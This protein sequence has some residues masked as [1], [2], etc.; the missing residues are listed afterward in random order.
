MKKVI[1]LVLSGVL[2]VV[3]LAQSLSESFKT[4]T[5]PASVTLGG[6]AALTGGSSD[7]DGDGWLR[8]VSPGQ[9]PG[10]MYTNNALNFGGGGTISFDYTI[11]GGSGA[12]GMAVIFYDGSQ[13][14]QVGGG[15]GYLGYIDSPTN[16]Y[17]G[18][19]ISVY[20]TTFA[21]GSS[22][23][24][25]IRGS[26]SNGL[27][28]RG[29]YNNG[30]VLHYS[31]DGSRPGQDTEK[32]RKLIVNLSNDRKLTISVQFGAGN[33]PVAFYTDFD[34][35]ADF[36][37]DM[38]NIKVAIVGSVGGLGDIFEIRNLQIGKSGNVTA[39]AA[40]ERTTLSAKLNG[41][42]FTTTDTTDVRFLFGS[43]PGV[44]SDSVLVLDNQL[45]DSVLTPISHTLTG[46]SADT[47]YYYAVSAVNDSGY[48]VSGEVNFKTLAEE[49]ALSSN[50]LLA[51]SVG[52]STVIL[53]WSKTD[54]MVKH[55]VVVKEGSPVA[56]TPDDGV[57][58]LYNS[59]FGN[60]A[61]NADGSYIV[62]NGSLDSIEVTN[63]VSTTDY[64]VTIFDYYG[65]NSSE[66]YNAESVLTGSFS[67][68]ETPFSDATPEGSDGISWGDLA[69]ADYDQ[70]GRMDYAV[71]NYNFLDV[72]RNNGEGFSQ[73]RINGYYSNPK[74]AWGDVNNDGY[75][76]L[77]FSGDGYIAV[78]AMGDGESWYAVTELYPELG[79][80]D[81]VFVDY[82]LDGDQDIFVTGEV[83]GGPRKP[84][85]SGTLS[86]AVF[87]RNDS[88]VFS[89]LTSNLPLLSDPSINFGD[90]NQDGYPDLL[91]TGS[92]NDWFGGRFTQV[93]YGNG[94]TQFENAGLEIPQA[95]RG[96]AAIADFNQDGF[97]DFIYTGATGEGGRV[98]GYYQG[99]EMG[100]FTEVT[101]SLTPVAR[102]SVSAGDIDNDGD[103]DLVF[104]GAPGSSGS[105]IS[106]V[107][108]NDG[109]GN[110][111]ETDM[112]L[113]QL[114]SSTVAL[115]DFNDDLN[116]DLLI[117]GDS[118]ESS[119][120]Y[121]LRSNS[122]E[123]NTAP[124]APESGFTS[125]VTGNTVELTWNAGS[126]AETSAGGLTYNVR[127]GTASG[128]SGIVRP[129]SDK[130]LVGEEVYVDYSTMP[131]AGNAGPNTFF[132]TRRLSPGTYYWSVQTVDPTYQV[133][134]F[135]TGQSFEITAPLAPLGPT[136][137]DFVIEAD[138]LV[139]N[140]NPLEVSGLTHYNVYQSDGADTL[141][142]GT[143][144]T[145]FY[146]ITSGLSRGT[147]YTFFVAGVVEGPLEGEWSSLVAGLTNFD[148][149]SFPVS[150]GYRNGM[151]VGD[152][153]NDGKPDLINSDNYS[154]SFL[155]NVGVAGV[156]D[157]GYQPGDVMFNEPAGFAETPDYT[158][159]LKAADY[160]ND[161]LL[162]LAVA[163]GI[164]VYILR[165]D[166]IDPEMGYPIFTEV[167]IKPDQPYHNSLVWADLDNDGDLDLVSSRN[168]TGYVMVHVNQLNNE[169]EMPFETV[170]IIPDGTTE[171]YLDAADIDHDGDQDLLISGFAST[172]S[173]WESRTVAIYLNTGL[174]SLWTQLEQSF[175]GSFKGSSRF[176]D[177]NNDGYADFIS[178][179][180]IGDGGREVHLYENNQE[181]GF[182]EVPTS[183][184]GFAASTATWGD[185]NGDG[186]LDLVLTGIA[187]SADNGDE[188]ST[189]VWFNNG[190]G[191]F[192]LLPEYFEGMLFGSVELSDL[193]LDG[194]LD[195]VTLGE[196]MY[197]GGGEALARTYYS[198]QSLQILVNETGTGPNLPD[199]PASAS[200]S[201]IGPDYANLAW[202]AGNDSN[203]PA[204][205]LTYNIRVYNQI[206]EKELVSVMSDI[207]TGERL[208]AA[209]GNT[210][211]ARTFSIKGLTDGDYSWWIQTI[212][213]ELKASA[214][215]QGP[216]FTVNHTV[217]V[218]LVAFTAVQKADQVVL[219]WTTKTE[220][221][222]NGFEIEKK[223]D[224]TKAESQWISVG[225]V[226]GA[227]TTTEE[228][229]YRFITSSGKD[230]VLFRLKQ[231]DAD[232]K[233]SYS[234]VLAYEPAAPTVLALD[235]NYPNP[236]NPSTS[237]PVSLPV[238]GWVSMKVYDVTGREV[239]ILMNE[240]KEA[241]F[242]TV[243]FNGAG[244]SSGLYFVRLE[245][246]GQSLVK[247][248]TLLK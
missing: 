118:G 182:I 129:S 167:Y 185:L 224:G 143:S 195:V 191:D 68:L 50:S 70:D 92:S 241:G 179:G 233:V 78:F 25:A 34:M 225:F 61:V 42:I 35:S 37:S 193:D 8:L 138:T 30:Q 116:L 245:T 183:F 40:T 236:F 150:N 130:K 187:G 12:D 123:E 243:P 48:V 246:N 196:R 62:Y 115:G 240:K 194:D 57:S 3:V 39:L 154:L 112:M 19:A 202:T 164:Y 89:E 176:G 69:W 109:A 82:D 133:S 135:S 177:F 54:E 142:I 110:F 2:P 21:N 204:S 163:S 230:R 51:D 209:P 216:D 136:G 79:A 31:L 71:T 207:E 198:G 159:F 145:T 32:Y 90:L 137:L 231:L 91:L 114:S 119:S 146:R 239:A 77:L 206:A 28:Y 131:G 228:K 184:T 100:G 172:S 125:T 152:F 1:M 9:Q 103:V 134:E 215:I 234:D 170:A 122:N 93:Y 247:K 58:Y 244:L 105:A 121:L 156:E 81:A 75:L 15:G 242:Y 190:E 214:W 232:G 63:L 160:N 237:I 189:Q 76:E 108:V 94:T 24:I 67:T 4:S 174:D 140:W 221:N 211:S 38:T 248:L 212:N 213:H 10:Y 147:F 223:A 141:L 127:I 227:G 13:T 36:P 97:A 124:S 60:T 26:Q 151:V 186:N 197:S 153:D 72:Y 20:S 171:G 126:D 33:E 128:E 98:I 46:L 5:V 132:I 178:I 180:A 47:Y 102:A 229:T 165:N 218:E 235:Q 168:D 16:I 59:S 144:D 18:V 203:T 96:E 22:N 7:P 148:L 238:A 44:Y 161:G 155:K 205:A 85:A 83:G 166:G 181:G 107:A 199:A 14:F 23:S 29:A 226:A 200:V 74:L 45:P 43:T 99:S 201:F 120:L 208:L 53:D 87:Y 219:S 66:N 73:F 64:Y 80:M 222:N 173:D 41:T 217:P 175:P 158:A 188:R 86:N 88:G 220:T 101:H 65:S 52:F 95:Y 49:P 113:P 106:Y 192:T 11:W 27:P 162:D 104:S 111:T 210:G 139:L 149:Q 169:S 84:V 55:L 17:A 56:W 157:E 117:G 6:P